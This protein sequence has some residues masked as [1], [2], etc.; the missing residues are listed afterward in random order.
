MSADTSILDLFSNR[1]R[2][3]GKMLDGLFRPESTGELPHVQTPKRF[4][5]IQSHLI[6]DLV[7]I[8]PL[9][10]AIRGRFPDAEITLL[11]NSFAGDLF[12]DGKFA[13]HIEIVD[14]PW[15]RKNYSVTNL[16]SFFRTLAAI[17]R[18]S[19]EV[20]IDA[21]I[22][23]RNILTLRILG[24]PLRI[25]Y[26]FLGGGR[27]LTHEVPFAPGKGLQELRCGLLSPLGVEI[28]EEERIARLEVGEEARSRVQEF[29]SG[30]GL[31][32]GQYDV[33]HPGASI[34]EKRWAGAKCEEFL[35]EIERNR[36]VVVGGP[37]ET[38]LV[39]RLRSEYSDLITFSGSLQELLALLFMA[40][41]ALCMDSGAAHL[42]RAV[43]TTCLVIFH[44]NFDYRLA[45][46]PG[47]G[48][49]WVD[50]PRGES[51]DRI[52]VPTVIAALDAVR[53]GERSSFDE[54]G[55]WSGRSGLSP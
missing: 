18:K 42:A 1:L 9:L 35:G 25:G 26:G 38:R 50:P 31:E 27:F 40:R 49:F 10:K 34:R 32:S 39:E 23:P 33:F 37:G 52:S 43:G 41:V 19:F 53:L 28:G 12:G 15:G 2:W 44:G 30:H 7:T 8:V 4:L 5:V 13:D 29:L 14:F 46:P 16:A 6:G 24:V 45:K 47:N 51:I 48:C 22:D 3:G 36:I 54:W 17:R 21:Q 20:G 11:A 55:R